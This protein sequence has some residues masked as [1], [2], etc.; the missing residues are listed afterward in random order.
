MGAG[1][2]GMGERTLP[3]NLKL[4]RHPTPTATPGDLYLD[5]AWQCKTL[6]DI[7][8]RLESGGK[9]IAGQ[10]AIPL[11]RYRVVIDYSNRFHRDMLHVLDVPQFEGIRIHAGNV[12]SDTEGCILV[13]EELDREFLTHSRLAL[14]ALER[15]VIE[16]IARDEEIWLTVERA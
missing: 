4:L 10:T 6:E 1:L 8:R 13:G 14:A 12:T 3:M 2:S 15:E 7:D 5:G 16:A 11:G 9:K